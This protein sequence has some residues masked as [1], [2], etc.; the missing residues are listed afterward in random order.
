MILKKSYPINKLSDK[1]VLKL[2]NLCAKYT[3]EILG[4][5]NRKRKPLNLIINNDDDAIS[6]GDYDSFSNTIT[7]YTKHSNTIEEFISTFI[8]E[9]TH[10]KQPIRTKYYKL[11]NEFGYDKHPHEL[12]ARTNEIIFFNS[13]YNKIKFHFR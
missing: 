13:V 10:Y 3:S 8:H 1:K 6:F 12:E 9:Y 11:L 2:C 4:L 5:N 7:I